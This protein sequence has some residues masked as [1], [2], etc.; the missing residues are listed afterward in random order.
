MWKDYDEEAEKAAQEPV[1]DVSTPLK[2]EY[3][4]VIISDV[5]TK[6]GLNFSV[7]IL[8]TEGWFTSRFLLVGPP[9]GNSTNRYSL[10]GEVD[11]RFLFAPQICGSTCKLYANKW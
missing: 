3:I 7:Q 2:P 10:A 5:R 11:A 4:D 1:E 9:T 6:N 8:N